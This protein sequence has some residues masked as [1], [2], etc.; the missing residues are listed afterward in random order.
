M[1]GQKRLL[2]FINSFNFSTF[3]NASIFLGETGCGKHTLVKYISDKFDVD[4]VDISENIN[5]DTINEIY[6][7]QQPQ[8]YI[9]NL[10]YVTNII[11][12]QNILLKLLEEP[13]ENS[14]IIIINDNI[15]ELLDTIKNRCMVFD[16]EPYSI[17]ELR[18]FAEQNN[19]NILNDDILNIL[20]TPGKVLHYDEVAEY[21]SDL[22]TL[23]NKILD[24]IGRASVPNSLSIVDKFDFSDK[25]SYKFL[26]FIGL[27]KKQLL[28][29]I[30]D[31][32]ISRQEVRLYIRAYTITQEFLSAY[33]IK[34]INKKQQFEHYILTLKEL[35][36]GYTGI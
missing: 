6:V 23:V 21:Y 26:T 14:K 15:E 22:N 12:S 24:Y 30:M 32:K 2:N 31:N 11:R 16:F 4:A 35:F 19:I 7:S 10:F 36:N 9:C 25:E 5:L 8:F 1:I 13:P 27:L 34:N 29:R 20:N 3:P 18:Q 17:S 33:K 28:T